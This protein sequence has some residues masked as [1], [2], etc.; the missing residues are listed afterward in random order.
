MIFYL[1]PGGGMITLPQLFRPGSSCTALYRGRAL[2]SPPTSS[3]GSAPRLGVCLLLRARESSAEE[4]RLEPLLHVQPRDLLPENR[5]D[6]GAPSDPTRCVL[7]Y[8]ISGVC[9]SAWSQVCV[10]LPDL[11]CVLLYLVSGVCCSTWSQVCIALPGLRCVLLYLVSGVCCCVTE[12]RELVSEEEH[13]LQLSDQSL[14]AVRMLLTQT[15]GTL[16][17]LHQHEGV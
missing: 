11:R 2:G 13:F 10:A 6:T 5:R 9:C 7:L 8:L 15:R 12:H 16:G 3:I 17:I 14:A 4:D 1:G